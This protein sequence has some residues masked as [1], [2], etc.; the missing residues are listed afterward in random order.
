MI[1]VAEVAGYVAATLV[2]LTFYMKTMIPLRIV[3]I[4]SNCIFIVYGYLGGLYPVN[5]PS[6][7]LAAQQPAAARD[8]PA[9]KTGK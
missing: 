6:H 8:A 7:T 1:L 5:F 4:C 9:H 3:G 2:F